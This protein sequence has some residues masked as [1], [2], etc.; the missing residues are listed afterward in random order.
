MRKIIAYTRVSKPVIEDLKLQFDVSYFE[1]YEYLESAKFRKAL[2]EAEGIIGL[3]LKVTKELL[4]LAP[5][6]KIVSNVSVGYDNLD[7]PEMTKRKIMATNTPGVLTDTVA[8]AV[9]GML[10]ASARRIPELDRFVKEGRWKEYLQLD[11][12]G[13]DVHHKKIGIIGMGAIGQAV[14][15]R[16][17]YG[18]DMK[19]LYYNRSR[20]PE[21]EDSYGAVFHNVED[22]LKESDFVVLMI[23]GSRETK[24]FIKAEHFKKMKTSAIFVNASRGMNIDENALYNA[25]KNNEILA[26]A[27]DVF[28]KE[29][30]GT[31][32]PLLSLP[33]VITLPHLGAATIENELAMSRLA[34][35]NLIR[36]LNNEIPPNL[37]NQEVINDDDI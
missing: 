8:D 37:I 4:G 27:L 12:F 24:H 20:K 33:N 14:A 31:D 13:T 18:F 10:I 25:L 26:A 29:P 17:H 23:P 35:K 19:I 32:N 5:N 21:V 7:L 9:V 28:E 1:N 34:Q 6:L 15:K 11:R 3:E 22:L 30:V 36:G 2:G 16:C